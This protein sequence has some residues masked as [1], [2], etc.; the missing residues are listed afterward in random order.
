M[1]KIERRYN[2]KCSKCG[3]KFSTLATREEHHFGIVGPEPYAQADRY[4]QFETTDR[5]FSPSR[6]TSHA[7]RY[8]CECGQWNR[9][10]PVI[11]KFRADKKCDARC[12]SATGHSCECS[13]G[14]KNHGAQHG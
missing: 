3:A 2:N 6:N 7:L 13:C 12:T 11:G 4:V 5:S 8:H 9:A 10:E 14:G 1:K